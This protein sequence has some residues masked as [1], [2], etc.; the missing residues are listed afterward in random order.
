MVSAPSIKQS[1]STLLHIL[2]VHS[3][4]NSGPNTFFMICLSNI[5]GLL[6]SCS[7][8][9]HIS[10]AYVTTGL[11]RVCYSFQQFWS[12]NFV[13]AQY[14]LFPFANSLRNYRLNM[15]PSVTTHI[16]TFWI[17]SLHIHVFKKINFAYI[18]IRPLKISFFSFPLT[19]EVHKL[20]LKE[21]KLESGHLQTS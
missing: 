1:S 19:C 17:T 16:L 4:A 10:E 20:I 7:L 13:F 8:R 5:Q 15:E 6:L 9:V 3:P 18:V 11:I 21:I 12:Y 2:Q 14:A